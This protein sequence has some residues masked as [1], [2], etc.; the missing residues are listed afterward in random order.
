MLVEIDIVDL[1]P[2]RLRND[3]SCSCKSAP[4]V[5]IKSV[6]GQPAQTEFLSPNK[7]RR[8]EPAAEGRFGSD[9]AF[10]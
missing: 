6:F 4:S 10:S 7:N 2:I 9:I 5:K 8:N 1:D 3:S